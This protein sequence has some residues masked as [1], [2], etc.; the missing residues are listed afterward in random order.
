MIYVIRE[1]GGKINLERGV[2]RF[3]KSFEK[4]GLT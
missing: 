1:L 2:G 4:R 3:K